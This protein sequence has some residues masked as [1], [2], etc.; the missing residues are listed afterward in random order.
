MEQ[1]VQEKRNNFILS[2]LKEVSNLLTTITE[3]R[4]SNN[5]IEL[6]FTNESQPKSCVVKFNV[7]QGMGKNGQITM[8]P[9]ESTLLFRDFPILFLQQVS[10]LSSQLLREITYQI[11]HFGNFNLIIADR[12]IGTTNNIKCVF[13]DLNFTEINLD[14]YLIEHDDNKRISMIYEDYNLKIIIK[15]KNRGNEMIL[16]NTQN[17]NE[18]KKIQKNLS[19]SLKLLRY[20]RCDIASWKVN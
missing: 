3:V 19:K 7:S 13:Y 10:F 8:P 12:L 16:Q 1:K 18:I 4:T 2:I 6:Y 15:D 5:V 11:N 9:Q 20:L 17:L 14:Q